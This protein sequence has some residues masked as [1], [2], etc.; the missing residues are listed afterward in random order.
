M[1]D[2]TPVR[3]EDAFDIGKVHS[4]LAPYIDQSHLPEVFQFRSGASNLT[5][6]LK[7]PDRELVLRRPPVGTKA[8]SAHDM[9]REFL[10]QSRLKPVFDL[11]PNVIALC[12]D[13]QI[14]GSDFYVMERVKGEI[15]RRDVP[16]TLRKE[17]ISIMADSLVSGLAGFTQL[18][19]LFWQNLIK[20]QAM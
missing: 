2:L 18:M 17:D 5:Y 3:D 10:I 9:K 16:E 1:S 13:H 11:V 8:I 4:W 20:E 12:D 19:P 7:Y 15:F 14:L 6:L